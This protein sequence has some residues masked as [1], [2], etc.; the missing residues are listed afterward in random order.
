MATH[1]SKYPHFWLYAK[2]WYERGDLIEDTRKLVSNYRGLKPEHVSLN[3][4]FDLWMHTFE[5]ATQYCNV[6]EADHRKV[7]QRIW[8]R[9]SPESVV[10]RIYSPN[11]YSIEETII[12]SI[13]SILSMVSVRN[14][15]MLAGNP[16]LGETPF[17][18]FG[19][20]DPRVLPL[21]NAAKK[22]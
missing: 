12:D 21:S 18:S 4:C 19:N 22:L 17:I 9:V 10:A 13:I 20:P 11:Q 16:A 2:C 14:S 1:S 8:D 5:E 7:L 3:D 15:R 6:S